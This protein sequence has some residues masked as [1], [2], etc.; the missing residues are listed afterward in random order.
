MVVFRFRLPTISLKPSPLLPPN[1]VCGEARFTERHQLHFSLSDEFTWHYT[2]QTS[3]TKCCVFDWRVYYKSFFY[4][5]LHIFAQITIF[6]MVSQVVTLSCYLASAS[7]IVCFNY[8]CFFFFSY[9][10]HNDFP[11]LLDMVIFLDI[12]IFHALQSYLIWQTSLIWDMG[13]AF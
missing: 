6:L 10:F 2:I 13:Y 5:F 3:S 7:H 11:I 8:Y 9:F 1:Q 4:T 12:V